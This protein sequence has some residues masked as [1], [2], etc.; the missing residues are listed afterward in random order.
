M[1]LVAILFILLLAATQICQAA[2]TGRP[3]TLDAR[4]DVSW[5]VEAPVPVT[6]ATPVTLAVE[7][8]V[9]SFDGVIARWQGAGGLRRCRLLA[10]SPGLRQSASR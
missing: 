7:T 4:Y 6:L 9:L 1:K 10:C 3:G 2:I 8:G 5:V